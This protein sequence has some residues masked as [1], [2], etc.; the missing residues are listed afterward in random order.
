[1]YLVKRGRRQEDTA[2]PR[3]I[4]CISAP[5]H[6]GSAARVAVQRGAARKRACLG[7]ATLAW[8]EG[9]EPARRRVSPLRLGA[10]GPRGAQLLVMIL[11]RI[12]GLRGGV[13]LEHGREAHAVLLL[14]VEQSG[15][16]GE[17]H[18]I[19]GVPAAGELAQRF[20]VGLA[21]ANRNGDLVEVLAV[22]WA[23]TC[24]HLEEDHS[25][26]PDV[27]AR[28]VLLPRD[29]LGRHVRR[30]A[31][32]GGHHGVLFLVPRLELAGEPEVPEEDIALHR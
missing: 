9:V 8:F 17:P 12:L 25:H 7:T 16:R 5:A 14:R 3:Y 11:R 27:R 22:E 21:P 32:L 30:R 20:L 19:G 15:G 4:P 2:S 31:H 10:E 24:Q 13:L 29:Q 26:G 1:M 23:N 28:P 6:G 18:N